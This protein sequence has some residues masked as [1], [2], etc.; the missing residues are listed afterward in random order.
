[1]GKTNYAWAFILLMLG[2][3]ACG[4][5]APVQKDGE[6]LARVGN[7]KLLRA[8]VEKLLPAGEDSAAFFDEYARQWVLD[9]LVLRKAEENV[10]DKEKI[11]ALVEDYRQML[12]VYTYKDELL[13][14]NVSSKFSDEELREY[15]E[16][17]KSKL[18]LNQNLVKGIFLKIPADAPQKD[19]LLKNYR[20]TSV[21]ALE[22][23]EKYSLRNA[24]VYK[25]FYDKWVAFGEIASLMPNVAD[26]PHF[27]RTHKYYEARD[28][29][30]IYML[31]IKEYCLQGTVPPFDYA[32]PQMKELM[33]N[34][35]KEA[36]LKK[37]ETD[38][39]QA[40]VKDSYAEVYTSTTK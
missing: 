11:A 3:W 32:K 19:V 40:A 9:R 31:A 33:M 35:Q 22:L 34:E 20:S 26:T 5:K 24:L 38:L 13:A 14:E 39:L 8:E 17:N 10:G 2:G 1:M 37:F 15:Y 28:G 4:E 29:E 21:E 23:I 18:K 6:V 7:E 27:L 16:Q 30:Y 12:T 25:Y 36:F